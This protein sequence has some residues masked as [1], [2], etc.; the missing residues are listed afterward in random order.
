MTDMGGKLAPVHLLD[1]DAFRGVVR[2]LWSEPD[3]GALR[4]SLMSQPANLEWVTSDGTD[5]LPSV[6]EV[7][8]RAKATYTGA[9]WRAKCTPSC[10]WSGPYRSFST[11]AIADAINHN[12][13]Y[14]E[15]DR[16]N[17]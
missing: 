9:V 16:A 15:S 11:Q 12:E 13:I 1:P 3:N 14:R 4:R 8:H 17:S 10:G 7:E 2:K 6:P 5:P